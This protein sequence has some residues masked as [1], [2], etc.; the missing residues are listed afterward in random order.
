MFVSFV[1]FV[2]DILLSP[3]R[4]GCE[5]GRLRL[6]FRVL[7]GK[8]GGADGLKPRPACGIMKAKNT[9]R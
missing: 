1:W 9:G 6:L 4:S 2:S 7:P 5:R 3:G 8:R